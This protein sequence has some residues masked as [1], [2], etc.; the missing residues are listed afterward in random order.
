MENDLEN[1]ALNQKQTISGA[2]VENEGP[3]VVKTDAG[4]KDGQTKCPK[5]GATDISLNVKNGKLRC[6]F[7]RCEFEP[8]KINEIDTDISQ[9]EGEVIGSG[10]QEIIADTNDMITLKCTSCGAEV[11]INTA[12]VTQARCHWC[13]NTLSINEQISNGA[14][15]DMILPFKI[16][17][18]EA[19]NLIEKFAKTRKIFV[20]P[21]F[22]KDFCLENIMGVYLPYMVVDVNIHAKLK[23]E[24]RHKT[25]TRD[26][27]VYNVEREFDL[28]IDDLTVESSSDKLGA[29]DSIRKYKE[30]NER[31]VL[32]DKFY[33][34]KNTNNIINAIMPFDTENCVKWNANYIKGYTSEKRDTNVSYLKQLVEKQSKD[35][36]RHAASD[37]SKRYS[38]RCELDY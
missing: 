27:A 31:Y 38:E 3:T 13:R 16:P 30:Y 15:P 1:E 29:D 17:K 21:Q 11:I 25:G 14:V 8:E 34:N 35:I 37:S 33:D 23:G 22:K 9:L 32:W 12:N 18:E 2:N 24:G 36:V 26:V 28:E 19:I 5:C 6:N 4:A 10:A 7:C 20:E